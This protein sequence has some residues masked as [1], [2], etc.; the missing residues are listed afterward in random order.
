MYGR[1]EEHQESVTTPTYQDWAVQQ[2]CAGTAAC[3]TRGPV[4]GVALYSIGRAGIL[5][6]NSRAYKQHNKG[7]AGLLSEA[8]TTLDK[9]PPK[10]IS[11][12]VLS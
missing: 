4:S 10:M 11:P 6:C 2:S 5:M 3:P 1:E 12:L 9:S 7:G 8:D